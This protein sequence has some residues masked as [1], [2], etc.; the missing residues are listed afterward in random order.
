MDLENSE[1]MQ[2]PDKQIGEMRLNSRWREGFNSD[3][4][5]MDKQTDIGEGEQC[6]ANKREM[7]HGKSH[8]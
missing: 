1:E 3:K 5:L 8:Q 2:I 6:K 7:H 4:I